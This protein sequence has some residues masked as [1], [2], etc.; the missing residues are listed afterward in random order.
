MLAM[1]LAALI[2]LLGIGIAA[3]VMHLSRRH[4]SRR[5]LQ[6]RLRELQLLSD[7]VNRLASAALD[8]D[9]LIQLVYECAGQM[10][11]VSNF[12]LGLFEDDHYVVRLHY[13]AGVRQAQS[14]FNLSESGGIVG[15]LRESAQPLL[16]RDFQVE[17]DR[18]PARPRYENP[19]PP[20]SAVFV[21]MVA[22]DQVIGALILQ[23]HHVGAYDESH[24]RLLSI[25]A[26]QA[27]ATIQNARALQ[28]ERQRAHQM[29]LVS[30]VAQA[31]AALFDR[32]TL[33][34]QLVE[35][36]R[37]A[38]HCEFVSILLLDEFDRQLVCQA[39]TQPELIGQ[40]YPV[41]TGLVGKCVAAGQVSSADEA[42]PAAGAH[43]RSEVALPL[44]IGER[45]IGVLHLRAAQPGAFRESQYL[46]TLAQQVAIAIEEARLYEQLLERR[47]LEQ[48]LNFAREIQTSFLPRHSPS[49]EGWSICSYWKVARHVGGDFYDYLSL[50]SGELGVVIADVVGKGVPAALFMVMARTLMRAAAIS[51]RTPAQALERVN[52]LIRSDSSADLFV[53]VLYAQINPRSGTVRLSSAGHNPPLHCDALGNVTVCRLRGIALGVAESVTL[54]EHTLQLCPGDVLLLYTDGLIDALNPQGDRFGLERLMQ[55]LSRH[56]ALSAEG[57]AQALR[58][59]VDAFVADEPLF[60]DETFIVIKR[61]A[62]VSTT[63]VST[64]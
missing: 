50:P 43:A 25:I 47:Q 58:S 59:E 32:R 3:L 40:R 42:G 2:L 31:T 60:D 37:R 5:A 15:W 38:F 51:P 24:L 21:P 9:A 22:R 41:G 36:V 4:T 55:A 35:S 45:V 64:A 27:A 19:H 8:E 39:A 61:H 14:R 17:M 29:A 1:E 52:Q 26:N 49:L 46:E 62:D 54:E 44:C 16:V 33:L 57:I 53:T 28:R 18:L 20:R 30:E 23:S 7:A 12:Q 6:A 10:M 11:D 63:A 34:P 56:H 48:E 13:V